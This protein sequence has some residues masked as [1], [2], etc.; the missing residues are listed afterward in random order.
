MYTT[1]T[2][3]DATPMSWFIIGLSLSH[4]LGVVVPFTFTTVLCD[5]ENSKSIQ[6]IPSGFLAN[7]IIVHQAAVS[8]KEI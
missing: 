5:L 8:L 6:Y 1:W 2:V 4:L 7:L 3:D